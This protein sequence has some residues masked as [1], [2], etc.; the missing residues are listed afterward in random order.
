MIL[1]VGSKG[2]EVK[3]LQSLLGSLTVDGVFGAATEAKV[4]EFQAQNQLDVDGIVG[5]ETQLA[6]GMPILSGID[7]S[8]YQKDVDWASLPRDK[9]QFAF[10]RATQGATYVD[11]YFAT[12]R[13]GA[14]DAAIPFGAYHFADCTQSWRKNLDNFCMMVGTLRDTDLPPVL[15]LEN[16]SVNAS[17]SSAQARDWAQYWLQGC[18]QALGVRPL[19]YTSPTFL[20]EHAN[21]GVGLSYYADL[22]V[23]RWST[24]EP[25]VQSTGEWAKW[26]IWQYGQG[27]IPGIEGAVDVNHMSST[28]LGRRS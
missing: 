6:L 20:A 5:W 13:K 23:A 2:Q 3:R 19:L 15:D 27:A 25:N 1:K 21:K 10:A 24:S 7:V 28:W 8:R 17:V 22:W 14:W 26:S 4:K 18:Q 11:P 12:N 16:E 9:V